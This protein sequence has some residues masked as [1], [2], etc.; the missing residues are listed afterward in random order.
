[1]PITTEPTPAPDPVDTGFVRAEYT[2]S[3]SPASCTVRLKFV[4]SGAPVPGDLA[5]LA[6]ALSAGWNSPSLQGNLSDQCTLDELVVGYS[7]GSGVELEG[8]AAMGDPGLIGG[9]ACP[10]NSAIVASLHT[11]ERYRGG[12]GRIYLPGAPISAILNLRE[13]TDDFVSAI[14]PGVDNLISVINGATSG[15]FTSVT[16]C[17]RHQFSAGAAL[18]PPTFTPISSTSIQRRICTQR[19]RLGDT[20]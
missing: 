18:T 3:G 10:V 9:G 5:A 15:P 20:L 12:K 2:V 11:G 8:G 6:T 7:F 17:V 16:A 14:G 19:R 13:W 4:T 1:M